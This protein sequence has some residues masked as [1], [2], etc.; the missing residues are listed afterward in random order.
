[1]KI[2][3]DNTTPLPEIYNQYLKPKW[4]KK[5]DIVVF[6]HDD[7]YVDDLKIRGKLYGAIKQFDII[8]VAGC[9]NPV[10]KAPT[11][12]HLMASRD[13]WR[14]YCAHAHPD[15]PNLVNMVSYG[16]T[17]SRVAV[18]DGLFMAVNLKTAI[19]SEWQFNDNFAFHHYDI[20]SCIDANRKR[21]KIG[22]IPLSL[23]HISLGL[24]NYKNP[25]FQASQD[26]FLEIYT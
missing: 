1:M 26:K 21:L 11:L 2:H 22:V 23:I 8:G 12:W 5:H 18:V 4:S 24:G 17:P 9:I 7:V 25:E 3:Y 16:H 10:L 6:V 13:N 19:E 20:S 14:G 15:D